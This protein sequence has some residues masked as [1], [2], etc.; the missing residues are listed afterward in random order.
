MIKILSHFVMSDLG[1]SESDK[2]MFPKNRMYF[3]KITSW[4]KMKVVKLHS[5]VLVALI[6]LIH[7]REFKLLNNWIIL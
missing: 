1:K 5:G 4:Y 6:L 7:L 2:Q 3:K